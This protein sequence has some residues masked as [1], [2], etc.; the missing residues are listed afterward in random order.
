MQFEPATFAEFAT[1]GPGG[2]VP[3]SPYDPVDAMYSA[4]KMLC[5]DGGGTASGL[6]GAVMAYNHSS[7][8]VAVVLVLATALGADP[9]LGATAAG[10]LQFAAGQLGIPYRWGGT[11]PGGFDCSGLVQAAYGA[12]GVS[13]PRVAQAQF[14][15]GPQVGDGQPVEPGDLVFFG[16]ATSEVDHVGIY[17]GAGEMIDAPHTGAEVRVEPASLTDLVGATRPG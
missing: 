12:V 15:A 3:A 4:A 7:S 1:V 6:A 17:M 2:A 8:Y 14:A 9:S 10:A 13:L 5:A 11:G 16:G